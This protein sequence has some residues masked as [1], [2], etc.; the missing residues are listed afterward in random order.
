MEK[1]KLFYYGGIV[2]VVALV[3]IKV[4]RRLFRDEVQSLPIP[5]FIFSIVISFFGLYIIVAVHQQY[6]YWV[7]DPKYLFFQKIMGK[8]GVKLFY[9]LLG[10][11]LIVVSFK[12]ILG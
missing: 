3:F 2:L 9:Y 8:T 10:I 5:G 6:D 12:I 4:A 7:E 1:N 11:A